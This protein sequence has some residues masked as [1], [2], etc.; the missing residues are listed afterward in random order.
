MANFFIF[1]DSI[2]YGASDRSGGW[3]VK[4]REYIEDKNEFNKT[5]NELFNLGISGDTSLD[6]IKRFENEIKCRL[7]SAAN[8]IF[9]LLGLMI[10]NFF[11]LKTK[12]KL[13]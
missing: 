12:Q 7:S 6:I 8:I 2:S 4:F 5:Y 11:L 13:V 1:G 9:L 3:V 10:H